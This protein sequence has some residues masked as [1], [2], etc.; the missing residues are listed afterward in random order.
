M[1]PQYHAGLG[2][3]AQ[4]IP[5]DEHITICTDRGD[6]DYNTDSP[7]PTSFDISPEHLVVADVITAIQHDLFRAILLQPPTSNKDFFIPRPVLQTMMSPAR[8]L[9]VIQQ[10]NCCKHLT[11]DEKI[12]LCNKL[13]SPQNPC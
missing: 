5:K 11:A 4:N 8:A 2:D 12:G 13:Y 10:L 9:L 6:A 3:P 1:V 7:H